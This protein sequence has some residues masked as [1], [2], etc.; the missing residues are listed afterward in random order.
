M[1][2]SKFPEESAKNKKQTT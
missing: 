2:K 1:F